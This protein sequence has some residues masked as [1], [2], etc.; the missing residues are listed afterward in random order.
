VAQLSCML[1]RYILILL[2]L[3]GSL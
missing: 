1:L 2:E 3:I